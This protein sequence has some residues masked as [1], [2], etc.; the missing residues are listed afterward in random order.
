MFWYFWR[1]ASVWGHAKPFSGR[2]NS[3]VAPILE[4]RDTV[5][6]LRQ[7][8]MQEHQTTENPA[9]SFEEILDAADI[10]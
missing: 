3:I 8:D 5:S 4:C 7:L 6:F 10:I 9:V 2:P 1:N